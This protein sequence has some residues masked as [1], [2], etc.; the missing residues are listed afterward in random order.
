MAGYKEYITAGYKES[1]L[2]I[3]TIRVLNMARGGDGNFLL[4]NE[5]VVKRSYGYIYKNIHYTRKI[6]MGIISK[7]T[8]HTFISGTVITPCEVS[9]ERAHT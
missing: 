8:E 7:K 5:H 3:N 1:V 4:R 9:I 6:N 2:S